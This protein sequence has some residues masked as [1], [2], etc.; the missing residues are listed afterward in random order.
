MYEHAYSYHLDLNVGSQKPFDRGRTRSNKIGTAVDEAHYPLARSLLPFNI[1]A[2]STE[3]PISMLARPKHK[4]P[5]FQCT[6][7]RPPDCAVDTGANTGP[8]QM[9]VVREVLPTA[10]SDSFVRSVPSNSVQQ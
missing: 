10:A 6:T 4:R 5:V 8:Y 7:K 1:P 9:F 3:D 2:S